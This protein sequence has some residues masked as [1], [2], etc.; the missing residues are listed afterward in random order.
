MPSHITVKIKVPPYIKKYLIAQSVNKK[1]PVAFERKHIY[2]ISLIQKISN[3]N[4]LEKI[5]L[6]EKDDVF[7]YFFNRWTSFESI[8]ILLPFNKRKDVR[9]FNYIS[10]HC[11][12]EFVTEVK[13]DFYFELMFHY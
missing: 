12:Q 4:Y 7:D 6:D 13:E 10:K 9:S 5:S 11:K 8:S 3:Y 1:E 2:N